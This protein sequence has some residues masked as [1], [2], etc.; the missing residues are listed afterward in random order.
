M[1]ISI[2]LCLVDRW[3]CRKCP[4][5]FGFHGQTVRIFETMRLHIIAKQ[6]V[7][8]CFHVDKQYSGNFMWIE[9]G[10]PNILKIK[11]FAP[12]NELRAEFN[13]VKKIARDRITKIKR[14]DS[15]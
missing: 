6:P 11:Y 12:F 4:R 8:G 7:R 3:K 15:G 2:K 9:I 14:Y 10:R 13:D 1:Y 5:C